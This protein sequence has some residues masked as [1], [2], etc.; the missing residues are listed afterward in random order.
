MEAL[1]PAELDYLICAVIR[2]QG[3]LGGRLPIMKRF[4]SPE[5]LRNHQ[6]RLELGEVLLQKL[7][8]LE[9]AREGM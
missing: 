8:E 5:H 9:R 1:E 6:A 3:E 7:T 2:M 4:G